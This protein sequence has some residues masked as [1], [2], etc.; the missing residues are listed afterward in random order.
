MGKCQLP[1]PGVNRERVLPPGNLCILNGNPVTR[2]NA[3]ERAPGGQRG[4]P[5]RSFFGRGNLGNIFWA[6]SES[7]GNSTAG[8]VQCGESGGRPGVE[9]SGEGFRSANSRPH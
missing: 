4:T 8:I 3:I 2:K 7:R 5:N 9:T 1:S 6:L